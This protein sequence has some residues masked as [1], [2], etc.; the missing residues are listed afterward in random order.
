MSP[1]WGLLLKTEV[2][3]N[4]TTSCHS[5]KSRFC[6]VTQHETKFYFQANFFYAQTPTKSRCAYEIF[7]NNVVVCFYCFEAKMKFRGKNHA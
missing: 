3:I 5:H 2:S 6:K 7:R 4:L 1:S